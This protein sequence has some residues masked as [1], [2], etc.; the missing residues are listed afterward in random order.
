MR[1]EKNPPV[2]LLIR[3]HIFIAINCKKCDYGLQP[4]RW[5]KLKVRKKEKKPFLFIGAKNRVVYFAEAV[6][7]LNPLSHRR[8]H[9]MREGGT[10]W[11]K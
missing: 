5:K 8:V 2:G 3:S 6:S 10:K 4:Y 7:A 1:L 11:K 9:S